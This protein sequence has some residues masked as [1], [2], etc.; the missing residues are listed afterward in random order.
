MIVFAR[1]PKA[2]AEGKPVPHILNSAYNDLLDFLGP[3]FQPLWC[4]SDDTKGEEDRKSYF[5]NEAFI[6]NTMVFSYQSIG[7]MQQ[8]IHRPYFARILQQCADRG[9]VTLLDVGSG[10][11]QLGLAFHALG[12]HVSLADVLSRSMLFAE[13]RLRKHGLDTIPIFELDQN[14]NWFPPVPPHQIVTCFDVL[15]HLEPAVQKRLLAWMGEIGGLVFANLIIDDSHPGMHLPID[16]D[17]LVAH[18]QKKWQAELSD[19]Y[20]GKDNKPRQHLLIYGSGV[21]YPDVTPTE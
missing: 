5:S 18:V 13:W 9:A 6:N 16:V 1:N 21:S 7:L 3:E 17:D 12:F 15:E 11:G 4:S 10:A 20:P 2:L 14:A 19:Y 8:G